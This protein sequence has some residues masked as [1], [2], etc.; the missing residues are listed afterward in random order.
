MKVSKQPVP[1]DSALAQTFNE[2][3]CFAST[4]ISPKEMEQVLRDIENPPESTDSLGEL[5]REIHR[6]HRT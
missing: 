1:A 5:L 2:A 4:T 3:K 6:E